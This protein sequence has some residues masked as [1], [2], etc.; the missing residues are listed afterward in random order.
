MSGP[1]GKKS[2]PLSEVEEIKGMVNLIISDSL[3]PIV[4]YV[5]GKWDPNYLFLTPTL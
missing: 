2:D 5:Q 4:S 1:S 3:G